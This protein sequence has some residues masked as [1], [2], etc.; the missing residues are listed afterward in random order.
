MNKQISLDYWRIDVGWLQFLP[1]DLFHR[2]AR[3]EK[4]RSDKC[5]LNDDRKKSQIS[6]LSHPT[7]YSSTD[8]IVHSET[9]CMW[10]T[11][12]K[13]FSMIMTNNAITLDLVI[14]VYYLMRCKNCI[15]Q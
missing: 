9:P 8:D 15:F 7:E 5:R 3:N 10:A 11:R 13:W 1:V 14:F 12:P 2:M 6:S 4:L